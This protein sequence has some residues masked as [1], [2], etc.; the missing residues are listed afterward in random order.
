MPADAA[1][2]VA[3]SATLA[4]EM[5]GIGKRF[6]GV[7]ALE[8]VDLRLEPGKVHASW[9]RTAPASRR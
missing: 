6:P 5:T 2:A 4:L 7:V 9:A 1:L 3:E 8:N